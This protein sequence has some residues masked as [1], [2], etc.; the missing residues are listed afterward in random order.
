MVVTGVKL[1]FFTVSG[2]WLCFGCVLQVLI[3]QGCFPDCWAAP[4][5]SQ[6]L[7][8]FSPTRLGVHRE[9][10]GDS[11]GTVDPS[12]PEGY[13]TP[14]GLMLSNKTRGCS[15][16]GW[17]SFCWR[18][19]AVST[20]ITCLSWVLVLSIFFSIIIY[21]YCYFISIIKLFITHK[22]SPVTLQILFLPHSTRGRC[23]QADVCCWL[24]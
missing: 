20:Y 6:S 19:T 17:A 18:R 1:I 23:E 24:N 7:S 15:G 4:A 11:A 2:M 9:L 22:F 12:W 3:T 14:Y 5:Q 16:T 8:C 10:G 21:Y 13:S